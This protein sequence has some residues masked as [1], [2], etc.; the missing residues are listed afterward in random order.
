TDRLDV[1]NRFCI[2]LYESL[3]IDPESPVQ[4]RQ[5]IVSHTEF[6]FETYNHEA[7]RAYLEK[8]MGVKGSYFVPK[9]ESRKRQAAGE[10]GFDSEIVV[11]RTTLMNL[12]TL[13]PAR[14]VKNYVD[15]FLESLPGLLR[16]AKRAVI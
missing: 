6:D 16:R 2:A 1:M 13:E 7:L 11:F 15:L 9:A 10:K 8:E 4:T 5:F 3:S 14:G 12:F